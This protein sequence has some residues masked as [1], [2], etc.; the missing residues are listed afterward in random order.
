MKI[1]TQNTARFFF[2]EGINWKIAING[3]SYNEYNLLYGIHIQEFQK[4]SN[5]KK[6][7][8][9]YKSF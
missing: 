2:T 7:K 4:V 6:Y 1:M 8:K 9:F 5:L 3:F